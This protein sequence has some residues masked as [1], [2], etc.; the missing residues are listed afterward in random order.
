MRFSNLSFR[1]QVLMGCIAA[2]VLTNTPLIAYEIL[3]ERGN[4]KEYLHETADQM[5]GNMARI[6]ALPLWDFNYPFLEDLIDGLAADGVV[7]S[8]ALQTEAGEVIARF[9]R[10]PERPETWAD[11]LISEPVTY[12]DG[13]ELVEL[14]TLTIRF[15]G[16]PAAAAAKDF[17]LSR[18][19]SFALLCALSTLSLFVVLGA[20]LNPLRNLVASIR[21][22]ENGEIDSA[23]K[24]I[25]RADEIGRVAVALDQLR[26]VEQEV[27]AARAEKDTQTMRERRRMLLALQSTDDGV[28]VTDENDRV[29]LQNDRSAEFFGRLEKGASIDRIPTL[30]GLRESGRLEGDAVH[31]VERDGTTRAFRV[32]LDTI[33]DE[34]GSDLGQVILAS[35]VTEQLRQQ[36]RADYLARHDG[37]TGLPNRRSLELALQ[38]IGKRGGGLLLCDLDRFKQVNDTLGHSVGDA[39]LRKFASILRDLADEDMMPVRLGGDEFAIFSTHENCRERLQRVGAEILRAL[40]SPLPIDGRPVDFGASLGLACMP[41][42]ASTADELLQMADVALYRAKNDGRGRLCVA[43]PEMR[44]AASRRQMIEATLRN[45]L[46]GGEGPLPVFQKQT[47]TQTKD[48]VGFEALARWRLPTGDVIGPDEFI[49]IAEDAGLIAPLTGRILDLSC[50]LAKTLQERGFHGRVSVN[51]SPMLFDGTISELVATALSKTGCDPCT[52]EIEI[53]EQVVLSDRTEVLAEIEA[54]RRQGIS[55]AL[56]DFGMGYSSLSYLKRFPVDKIKIDRAFVAEISRCTET[57]AIVRAIVEL[58]RALGLRV[59]AEGAETE[60]DREILGSCGVDTI[61]GWVDGKPV[62]SDKAIEIA[63]AEV[64]RLAPKLQRARG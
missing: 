53:T 18:I 5:V 27:H 9:S 48:I 28:I 11:T 34:A 63:G 20:V 10:T 49:P 51:A 47:D 7:E 55:V 22:I 21:K 35:D 4:Q 44:Q 17:A 57:Y 54:L 23:V 26:L 64:E 30:A 16:A 25:D 56:D 6:V 8:A 62:H 50:G 61:Q 45:N 43:E 2:L 60:K 38:G 42:D 24:D 37:L 29:V 40:S 46:D 41:D 52:L 58:S 32:R 36:E 19:T 1:A 15:S 14:G 31:M 59:T 13:A 12:Q 39:L 33:R 3:R